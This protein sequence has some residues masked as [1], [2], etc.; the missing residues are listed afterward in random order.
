M[1]KIDILM[2]RR[3]EIPQ[4]IDAIFIFAKTLVDYKDG[5]RR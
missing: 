3:R 5:E 1:I 2:K 4:Y